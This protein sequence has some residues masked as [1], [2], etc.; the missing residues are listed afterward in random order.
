MFTTQSDN[1]IPICPIFDII[2]LFAAKF[3]ELEIGIPG[4]GLKDLST[5]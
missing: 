3:K 4:E 1:C 2:S 5:S